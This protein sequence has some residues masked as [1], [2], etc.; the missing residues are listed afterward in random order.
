M[1]KYISFFIVSCST[2]HILGAQ[3]NLVPNSGFE[4]Y[5]SC[6]IG[7]G[8]INKAV[9]WSSP[10]I[11]TPDYFNECN[12]DGVGVPLNDGGSQGAN[13]GMAYAGI[14][15][16]VDYSPNFR[17]YI[18]VPLSDSLITNRKYLVSFY[19]SI[20]D[21]SFYSVKTI[22]ALLSNTAVSSTSSQVLP[23]SPQIENSI[24]VNL[25][26]TSLWYLI[27]DTITAL[28][29]EKY[30]T[31][32]NF[33]DYSSSGIDTANS[34]SSAMMAYYFVDDVSIVDI[35]VGINEDPFLHGRCKLFP[36]PSEGQVKF[37]YDLPANSE[38][39]LMICDIQGRQL[40]I[41]NLEGREELVI[42]T[43]ELQN[44]I[45][46]YYVLIN[47]FIAGGDKLIIHNKK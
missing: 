38:G 7:A 2:I 5:S 6:P 35:T 14:G 22:G 26:D 36:N 32:G 24:T 42:N 12:L 11:A 45:Y 25:N 1:K 43:S 3:P 34:S 28:G 17:D 27:S 46:F 40:S 18:Q 41:F 44:G 33:Q 47:N 20:A 10:T 39:K 30:I 15:C 4:F 21:S 29:G 37:K 23:Y 13:S 16:Y 8:E 31:I 19:V 9:P